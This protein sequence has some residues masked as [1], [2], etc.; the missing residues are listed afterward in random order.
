MEFSGF[1]FL[2]SS[3]PVD[4]VLLF[5]LLKLLTNNYQKYLMGLLLSFSLINNRLHL[6][7]IFFKT[8]GYTLS[9]QHSFKFALLMP[10]TSFSGLGRLGSL[11]QAIKKMMSMYWSF[12]IP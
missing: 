8:R 12:M 4:S 11:G 2:Y 3:P 9:L 10:M 5:F 1:S 6:S 7:C